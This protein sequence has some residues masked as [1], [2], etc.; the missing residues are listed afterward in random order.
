VR[1]RARVEH[2]GDAD[3]RE[4]PHDA[5]AKGLKH[6][7]VLGLDVSVNDDGVAAV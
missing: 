4:L 3:V 6:Q 1:T 7:N 5:T 2:L